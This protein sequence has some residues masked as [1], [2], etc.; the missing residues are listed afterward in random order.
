MSDLSEILIRVP[1]FSVH[2]G[3]AA[4]TAE[5]T[6]YWTDLWE[7]TLPNHVGI[8]PDHRLRA[9][10]FDDAREAMEALAEIFADAE[11]RYQQLHRETAEQVHAI[12][13]AAAERAREGGE[14]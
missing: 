1:R 2:A 4:L 13:S 10:T 11:V 7:L 8:D 3:G 14:S 9:R 6:N 5:N 12:V